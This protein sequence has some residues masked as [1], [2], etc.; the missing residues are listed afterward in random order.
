MIRNEQE[1]KTTQGRIAYFT[2]LLA[3]L[4]V[5]ASPEEF[6]AVAS[7]YRAEVARMQ[8]EVVEYLSRIPSSSIKHWDC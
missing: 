8:Q 1:L 4:R 2:D 6:P 5:T 7:G 3:Q